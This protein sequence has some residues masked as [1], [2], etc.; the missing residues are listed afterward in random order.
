M[1]SARRGSFRLGYL[2]HLWT[3]EPC[4]QLERHLAHKLGLRI[5]EQHVREP[6]HLI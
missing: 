5:A 3:L 1:T 2:P 4:R 6:T